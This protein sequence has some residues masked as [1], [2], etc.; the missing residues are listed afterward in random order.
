MVKIDIDDVIFKRSVTTV[1]A[2]IN[3][4]RKK[5]QNKE[6]REQREQWMDENEIK[7]SRLRKI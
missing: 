7:A 1:F 2:K 6:L 4:D 3:R 5:A